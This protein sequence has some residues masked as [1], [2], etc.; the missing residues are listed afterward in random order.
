MLKRLTLAIA[1]LTTA[2]M[3]GSAGA[4]PP[5]EAFGD[6]PTIRSAKISPDGKV[7]VYINRIN[8]VDF[9]AKFDIATGKNE[10]LIKIPDIK[11]GGVSFAGPNY[12][13]LRASIMTANGG[14]TKKYED[15]AA[16]AYNLTTKKIVQLLVGTQGLYSYQSGLGQI[17]GISPDGQF[18]YMPGYMEKQGSDPTYDLL[19][20]NLDTGR[21]ARV[22]GWDGTSNTNGW[23]L[24]DEGKVVA[25]VDYSEK[26]KL[27]E[28]RA[29]DKSGGQRVIYSETT[30]DPSLSIVGFSE[31][32]GTLIATHNQDS[33]FLQM[34]EMSLA[35]G[36]LTGPLRSR[37]NA[38]IEGIIRDENKVVVGVSYSGLYPSY[39]IFDEDLNKSLKA[40]INVLPD[41]AVSLSSWSDDWSKILLYAEGGKQPGRYMLF[42][43]TAKK[44][45]FVGT[46]TWVS[47]DELGMFAAGAA[48][49]DAL[50]DLVQPKRVP[51]AEELARVRGS[52]RPVSGGDSTETAGAGGPSLRSIDV[53]ETLGHL[54]ARYDFGSFKLGALLVAEDE[55]DTW[56]VFD[57]TESADRIV[58]TPE[59]LR[60][61]GPDRAGRRTTIEL[62][63]SSS[64][65]EKYP[66]ME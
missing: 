61:T 27:Y 44:A 13:I 35:D 66:A 58:A 37:G 24:N 8:G 31:K 45:I 64:E 53:M 25:R 33:D 3:S 30:T 43:R 34:Y 48:P 9:L 16:F 20:V 10:A 63:K 23:I 21:G 18:A 46:N 1:C 7:I 12:V 39:D 2:V 15:T 32:A 60:S 28:I 65:P 62:K 4:K 54:V 55:P 22:S 19:K 57:G 49:K 51:T 6:A 36:K 5:L 29:Y 17:A 26:R 41:A 50:L 52:F 14:L 56:S 59:G 47:P 40:A 42:D 11:A 38:E